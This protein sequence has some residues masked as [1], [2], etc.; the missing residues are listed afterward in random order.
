[1]QMLSNVVLAQAAEESLRVLPAPDELFWGSIAF[2]I[3]VGAL[4]KFVFPKLTTALEERTK[5]IQGQIEEAEGVK[6]EA[7]LVLTEY[8]QKL[9]DA[10]TDV[11]TIIEEGKRTAESM[12][13]DIVARAEV[14][15]REIVARAQSDV[16]GERDRAI[17]ALKDTLGDLS[18]QL[19]SR[20]I[21]KEL[22]TSDA[23][24]QLVD[25]AIAELGNPN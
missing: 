10:R 8:R 19:A 24:R 15:A 2:L 17:A 22:S 21:G 16:A 4:L 23:H 18:I 9:A 20:V 14:E 6:R 1:M 25:R 13:A 11:N 12:R 5:R 7:D 3:V